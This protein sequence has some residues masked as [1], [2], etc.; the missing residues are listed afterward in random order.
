MAEIAD[1]II[2]IG[3]MVALEFTTKPIEVALE[4]TRMARAQL[5][6]LAAG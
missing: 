4:T 5:Q 1:H 2:Y 3:R 6:Q